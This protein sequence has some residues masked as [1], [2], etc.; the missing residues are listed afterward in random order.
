MIKSGEL[1][2]I[3]DA[4]NEN[5]CK[6]KLVLAFEIAFSSFSF[7]RFYLMKLGQVVIQ[8]HF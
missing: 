3:C 7:Y 6:L 4:L 2:S 5:Y 1:C 8:F